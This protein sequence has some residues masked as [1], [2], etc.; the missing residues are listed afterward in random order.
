L[1]TPSVNL[2]GQSVEFAVRDIAYPDPGAVLMRLHGDELL[3]GRVID[4]SQGPSEMHVV[5]EVR[6][7]EQPVVVPIE[8]VRKEPEAD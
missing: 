1:A 4:V 3:S 5:V 7:L 8:R 6:G 2:R